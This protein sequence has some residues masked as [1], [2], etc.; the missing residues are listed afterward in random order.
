MC[1]RR[2]Q[3]TPWKIESPITTR[4]VGRGSAAAT[5]TFAVNAKHDMICA[6]HSHQGIAWCTVSV[7]QRG[8]NFAKSCA[9]I[10]V[11]A[12]AHEMPITA[13][14]MPTDLYTSA[15]ELLA[16]ILLYRRLRDCPPSKHI[17]VWCRADQSPIIQQNSQP[18]RM[19]VVKRDGRTEPMMF[20]KITSRI[21]KL[22]FQPMSPFVD[23]ARVAQSV[24]TSVASGMTTCQIDELAAQMAASKI[25]QH[26]DYG[27][28]AGRILASN[29]HKSTLKSFSDTMRRLHEYTDPVTGKP[30]PRI[31]DE[32]MKAV[33]RHREELDSAIIY[34]RDLQQHDF[35]SM[36]TLLRMYLSPVGER[37]QH[38]WMRVALGI[39]GADDLPAVLRTYRAMSLGEYTHATPTLFN[40]GTVRPQMASCFLVAM[41]DDS[42][43]GIYDTMKQCALISKAAGGIG[44]SISNVRAA[45]S[46]IRGTGGLSTGLVPMLRVINNTVRYVNQGGS[47]AG[48]EKRK[49]STAVYLEPWHADVCEFLELRNNDA[50]D[51]NLRC[52]DLEL[53]LWVPDLFM[54]RVEQ[55]AM[56]SLMC[57]DQAPGLQDVWGAEFDRLYEQY[58]QQPQ[59]YVRRQMKARDLWHLI[60]KTQMTTSEPYMMYKDACNRRSNQQ[61]VGTIRGS[62]LCSEIVEYSDASEVAVCNLASIALPKFVLPQAQR[63]AELRNDAEDRAILQQP[64]KATAAAAAAEATSA[65][66]DVVRQAIDW[67]RLRQTAYYV[68]INLNRVIDRNYYTCEEARRS[69]LR[70]RPIGIGT[71]GLADVLMML[72]LPYTSAPARQL[73][74]MLFECIQFGALQASCDLA[75]R[76]GSYST[77]AGSPASR[78]QLQHDLQ[79]S[80]PAGSPVPVDS[81]MWPWQELRERIVK[82]GL[83]NSLVTA[84]MPTA[85]TSQLLGNMESMEAQFS[86][87][88]VRRVGAGDQ[89]CTNRHFFRRMTQLGLWNDEARRQLLMANGS[90]QTMLQLSAYDREVYK[91]IYELRGSDLIEMASERGRWIDQTQSLNIYMSQPTYDKLTSNHFKAWKLGDKSSQ[92]YLRTEAATD[93][94]KK[95]AIADAASMP[96][97]VTAAAAAAPV[98]NSIH[99][100]TDAVPVAAADSV[101]MST[102][103]TDSVGGTTNQNQQQQVAIVSMKSVAVA[104]T[105]QPVMDPEYCSRSGGCMHCE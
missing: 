42:I 10:F 75:Q 53:A 19:F 39:H 85:T 24:V 60:I 45:G 48:G 31:S 98:I 4:A 11:D 62:N 99:V 47:K 82:T 79:P 93:A 37:P 14:G 3:R 100:A 61:N 77:F 64:P 17:A 71:Q 58:E 27:V 84:Q 72:R 66:F 80:V 104:A 9:G 16:M 102:P 105:E 59:R 103:A 96:S 50:A 55:D 1:P 36:Q 67:E 83:R 29:L 81:G 34:D 88:F 51:Q 44:L 40:A 5:S 23:P 13:H 15:G 46:L 90:V 70:H 43:E 76:D 18:A 21:A 49:G 54:R 33:E 38:M 12:T 97:Y 22:C 28:L 95:T 89:T 68:C 7:M 91:T 69:N 87:L 73:N 57:P 65:I 101:V 35:F 30:S 6:V 52:K 25:S 32:T 86:N 56:W 94:I 63:S 74:S 41:R 26:P 78:G 2:H 92:Y 20:D 8:R